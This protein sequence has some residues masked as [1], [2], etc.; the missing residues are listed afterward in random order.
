MG[1]AKAEQRHFGEKCSNTME[2]S[3]CLVA[4]CL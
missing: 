4:H 3:L 2:T 1:A